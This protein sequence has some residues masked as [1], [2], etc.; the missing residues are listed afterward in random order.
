MNLDLHADGD[1]VTTLLSVLPA[2]ALRI[3]AVD[4][5]GKWHLALKSN[6]P[7]CQILTIPSKS[8]CAE[9]LRAAMHQNF[10]A[11]RAD[12]IVFES[13]ES[14]LDLEAAFHPCRTLLAPGG[15]LVVSVPNLQH[16]SIL[17]GLLASEYPRQ[18]MDEH[19]FTYSTAIKLFLDAGFAP[20]I[21][22]DVRVPIS[23]QLLDNLLPVL[24]SL[25]L[26]PR[27]TRRYLDA[28]R[29]IFRAT[30]LPE[31]TPTTG[32]APPFTF[33]ACVSDEAMLRDNL[34]ASPC[35][36]DG[37]IHEILL[38]RNPPSAAH[39]L[40]EGINRARHPI[41]IGV[42]QDVYLPRGWPERF[43]QQYKIAEARWGRIG[44][45]GVYGILKTSGGFARAGRVVDRDRLLG[46]PPPL[47]ALAHTLDEIV[48]AVRKD[49][50]MRFDL[51]LGFHF[52]GSDMCLSARRER[53]ASVVLQAEC[54]HHSRSV[55]VP[56]EF[57]DSAKVFTAK[58]RH[59]L[60]IA[61]SC[62]TI[63]RNQQMALW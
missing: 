44:V 28:I 17:R 51:G 45:A 46:E 35:L 10:A 6:R 18:L 61:T 60:P 33:V 7:E 57:A 50:P 21:V 12:C 32:Q 25:R 27:R 47:P 19:V 3:V 9:S 62:A 1:A 52:Y 39:G 5:L 36:R 24:Q 29:Y 54:F 53:W 4:N 20:D 38:V 14:L 37:T 30:P 8:F 13:P 34:L 31:P 40:N 15:T 26:N 41:V 2:N 23:Q 55:G 58:W 48:L 56:L 22:A 43:W 63:D 16:H 11:N 59:E 42:H 49:A